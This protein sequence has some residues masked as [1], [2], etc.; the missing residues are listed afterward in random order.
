MI[1]QSRDDSVGGDYENSHL[2][3]IGAKRFL[4]GFVPKKFCEAFNVPPDDLGQYLCHMLVDA[5]VWA[6]KP[7]S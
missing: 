6:T 1:Y 5:K 4:P 2:D 3:P 7:I